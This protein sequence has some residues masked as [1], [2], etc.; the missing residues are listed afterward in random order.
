MAANNV[1][2]LLTAVAGQVLG[3]K[4]PFAP[5]REIRGKGFPCCSKVK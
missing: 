4:A 1:H 2:S 3:I 5:I